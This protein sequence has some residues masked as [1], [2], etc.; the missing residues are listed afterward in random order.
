MSPVMHRVVTTRAETRDTCTVTLEPESEALPPFAPGQFAMIWSPGVGE[1]PISV[2]GD[3]ARPGPLVHTVRAVGSATRRICSAQPGDRVGVRGP[4]GRGWPLAGCEGRDVVLVAGGLGMAPLRPVVHHVLAG[5]GRFGRLVVLYGARG[6]ADLLYAEQ[7]DRWGREQGVEVRTTV[8][9]AGRGWTGSVGVVTRLIGRAE[10]DPANAVAMVVGPEV[11]MR[12]SVRELR[13]HGVP[14]GAIH[15]SL[16][17]NMQCAV[18]H[19]GHC[20]L[21]PLLVCRDGPVFGHDVVARW[22]E[23]REL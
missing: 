16:E 17:R 23:V 14:A 19:C 22:L 13:D 15:V 3:L 9:A 18:G 10:F 11:M 4:F 7:L 8:D 1:V 20:Q 12:F 5:R 2:S 6:P 21:G